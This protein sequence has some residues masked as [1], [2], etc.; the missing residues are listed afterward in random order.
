MVAAHYLDFGYSIEK[1]TTRFEEN[2]QAFIIDTLT[3]DGREV[4]YLQAGETSLP[5]I[6]FVHG[7]PTDWTSWLSYVCND[8]VLD[9]YQV[10]AFNRLGYED[11]TDRSPEP[12]LVKQ[13]EVIEALMDEVSYDREL[14]L[15]GHS[16]GAPVIVKYSILYPDRVDKLV[17]MGASV[18]PELEPDKWYFKAME[19]KSLRWIMP[20]MFDVSNREILP[21]RGELEK[22][23]P[24]LKQIHSEIL[25][26][27]GYKD[28]LVPFENVDYMRKE[29]VNAK[30]NI[31]VKKNSGHLFV[32]TK[33]D[34]TIKEIL[35][36]CE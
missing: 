22:M 24:E 9:K 36:F 17:L 20:E 7:S 10:L 8:D 29:F 35:E 4:E 19:K 14:I 34:E 13:A 12:D 23:K 18:D 33:S 2:D 5:M 1:V 6:V 21:L 16:Y 28:K 32:F 11:N 3:F 27:H 31:K 25:I 30:L 15:M 26:L